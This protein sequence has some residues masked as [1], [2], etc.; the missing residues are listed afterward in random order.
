MITSS[1]A[2]WE[3]ACCI[4]FCHPVSFI[5]VSPGGVGLMKEQMHGLAFLIGIEISL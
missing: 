2:F 5:P 4:V 1:D 3:L